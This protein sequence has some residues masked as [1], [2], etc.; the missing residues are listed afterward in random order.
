MQAML[1]MMML[2][3]HTVGVDGCPRHHA[4]FTS[5]ATQDAVSMRMTSSTSTLR[6]A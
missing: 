3:M 4:W 1:L 2:I 6:G 5:T